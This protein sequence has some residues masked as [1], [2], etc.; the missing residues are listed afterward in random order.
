MII[1][2]GDEPLLAAPGL[3]NESI[4]V[5]LR[6]LDEVETE[7]VSWY[8][9]HSCNCSHGTQQSHCCQ[10]FTIEHYNSMMNWCVKLKW[11]ER[12]MVMMGQ[13]M[14]LT[15]TSHLT[16]HTTSHQHKEQ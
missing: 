11:E 4:M 15:N 2:V 8:A 13:I 6:E 12:D 5:E 9:S 7:R 16:Q 1:V 3:R 14:T 10:Q